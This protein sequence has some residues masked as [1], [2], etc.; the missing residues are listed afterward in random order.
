MKANGLM[1]W[2]MDKVA[3]H[4]QM[5]KLLKAPGKMTVLMA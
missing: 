3:W 2:S 4:I 1:M 5:E